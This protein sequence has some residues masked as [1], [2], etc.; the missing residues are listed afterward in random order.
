VV[1]SSDRTFGFGF[2]GFFPRSCRPV[3][4]AAG[5]Q[6]TVLL[7]RVAT[8]VVVMPNAP[9]LFQAVA[10]RWGPDAADRQRPLA[11]RTSSRATIFAG[12]IDMPTND[13]DVHGVNIKSQPLID[14]LGIAKSRD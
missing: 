11:L 14:T 9:R 1:G 4:L 7:H 10:S 8:F 3:A 12:S 5:Q 2:A 13:W 6:L